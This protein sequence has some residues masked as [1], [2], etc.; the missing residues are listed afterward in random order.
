MINRIKNKV[1]RIIKGS[2][3]N[4][5]SIKALGSLLH[6]NKIVALDVGGAVSLQPH[7]HK[8]I[9][10]TTFYVYEPDTRSYND[11]VEK[12]AEKEYA[13]DYIYINQ[14]LS[15][16]GGEQKF[17]LTNE[18]TGSSL[19]KPDKN[20]PFVT[21]DNAYFFPC[22]EI[23]IQTT[24]ITDSLKEQN[25]DHFD[26]IKI[27]VQG[28]ELQILKGISTNL[29]N[30]SLLIELEVGLN[31]THENMGS[32]ETVQA[33]MKA[34]GFSLFDVRVARMY[35]PEKMTDQEYSSKKM[36]ISTPLPS[37]AARAWEFDA[38]FMR[39]FTWVKNNKFE[40]A[41]IFKLAAGY[42]TYNFYLE[43]IYLIDNCL[44]EN[45]I[46][47]EEHRICKENIIQLHAIERVNIAPVENYYK[48][49]NNLHWGQYMHMPYP[50][51]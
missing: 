8:L 51:T 29:L 49:N 44:N 5:Q 46:T 37:I 32:F 43:A 17:Y 23:T 20:N 18:P 31:A 47:V 30:T 42:C 15:E 11:L 35:L 10:N 26:F 12:K 36:N 16:A 24:T 19:L 48:G 45:M 50:S 22:K 2:V 9:G 41:K 27:D 13:E 21:D 28:A 39:D 6:N 3:D 7:W 33:F 34:N 1:F 38:V 4:K 14:G 25:L 40:K